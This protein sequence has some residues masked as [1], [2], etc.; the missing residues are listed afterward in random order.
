MRESES[1]CPTLCSEAEVRYQK[2]KKKKK[3]QAS[4]LQVL[5]GLNFFQKQQ[6]EL[7]YVYYTSLVAN[8]S[9]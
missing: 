7:P 6:V 3:N 4:S 2:K 8:N 1:T 9:F 5:H